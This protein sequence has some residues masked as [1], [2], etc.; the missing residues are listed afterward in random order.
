MAE[1]IS[2]TYIGHA[3]TIVRIGGS[4]LFT[5]PHFGRSTLIFPRRK[6]LP[7]SPSELP[8]PSAIL[9]S[10]TH[11][12]HLN[13]S[14]YKF[15]SCSV[16]IIVPEGSE[17][18]IGQYMPNP[19]IELSHFADHELVCGTTITA[20]PVRH[21]SS[22]ISHLGCTKSNAYLI[23]RP[24]Q[25][26]AVFFCA[27]SA[28]GDHFREAGKLAKIDLALLPIGG[29]SPAWL[30]SRSH[31]TPEEA[32]QA[33][34]DLNAD[35]MIP[36]HYGTFNLSLEP[37]NAPAKW[38]AKIIGEKEDLAT[39]IHPLAPGDNFEVPSSV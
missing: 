25:S 23:R 5:D 17:R 34:E 10:H 11:Y 22:R 24:D 8:T 6:A 12:D 39:H 20:L 1:N 36:I 2:C 26:G 13:I 31:M 33:F 38:L 27:D 35:H 3:T 16:P 15:I 4:S 7:F 28:Y 29:Y 18:A 21:R 19:I 32:V 30:Q 37:L 14:S 9:L